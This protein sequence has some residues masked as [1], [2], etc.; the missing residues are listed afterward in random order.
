MT[1]PLPD[2]GVRQGYVTAAATAVRRTFVWASSKTSGVHVLSQLI[3]LPCLPTLFH[4]GKLLLTHS[5]VLYSEH[6]GSKKKY[7]YIIG[8]SHE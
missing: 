4:M 7:I 3:V 8:Y 1:T 2:K 6:R 5:I